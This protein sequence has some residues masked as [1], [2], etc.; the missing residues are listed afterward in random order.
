MEERAARAIEMIDEQVQELSRI[1]ERAGKDGDFAAAGERMRRWKTR[2]VTLLSEHVHPDEAEKLTRR[3]LRQVRRHPRLNLQNEAKIY[4]AFL[5][6]LREVLKTHPEEVLSP[7]PA[8][9]VIEKEP[10]EPISKRPTAF[11]TVF[12]VHGHDE[13]NRLKLER[14]LRE[15]WYLE[16]IV[17]LSEP[18]KGRTLIE[19]FEQEAERAAYAIVLFTPDDLVEVEGTKYTQARPNAIFELGWFY[20]RL[21]R[22]RVCILFRKGTKIPSDLD[23]ITRIEFDKSVDEKI[24]DIEKELAE[25]GLLQKT[26]T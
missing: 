5:S 16:P 12:I 10:P 17:L 1:V 7:I 26:D 11:R 24:E 8:E 19:K 4:R 2:T 20:G 13:G 23:G 15:R 3:S 18:G 14:L 9:P 6:S 22:E 21:S 25:A